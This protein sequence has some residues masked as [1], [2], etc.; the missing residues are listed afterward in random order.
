MF[1]VQEAMLV[2]ELFFCL[3]YCYQQL[4]ELSFPFLTGCLP[5]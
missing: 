4:K 3:W 2:L 1:E 5:L